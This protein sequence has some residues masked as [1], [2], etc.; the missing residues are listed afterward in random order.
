M[1]KQVVDRDNRES[2]APITD[3]N[4]T[5]QTKNSRSSNTSSKQGT[6][7][8]STPSPLQPPPAAAKA[9]P[10]TNRGKNKFFFAKWFGFG[11]K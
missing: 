9:E 6:T 10:D 8:K 4:T 5:N 2:L 11:S 1:D 7:G 3:T